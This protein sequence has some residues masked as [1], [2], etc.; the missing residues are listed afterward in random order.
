MLWFVALVVIAMFILPGEMVSYAKYSSRAAQCRANL[1]RVG[2]DIFSYQA[3]H[4]GRMPPSLKVL[5][6]TVVSQ[7]VLVCPDSGFVNGKEVSY[8]YRLLSKPSSTDAICWDSRPQTRWQTYL[9]WLN[10]PNRNVLYAD[11]QVKN[12]PEDE[13][14]KL[15]LAG[16][17]WVAQ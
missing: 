16:Q 5:Y 11:G 14:Q 17:N 4:T 15:H 2:V 6:P 12:L 10:R 8:D 13:F 3:K 1:K 7:L 9:V